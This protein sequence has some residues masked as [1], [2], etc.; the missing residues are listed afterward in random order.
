MSGRR[1]LR[2]ER[3]KRTDGSDKSSGGTGR[4]SAHRW[5][6]RGMRTERRADLSATRGVICMSS[7]MLPDGDWTA[8]R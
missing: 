7:V 3:Q 1:G 4:V 5:L 2:V 8:I 6:Y